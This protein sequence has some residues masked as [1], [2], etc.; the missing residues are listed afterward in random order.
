MKLRVQDVS[1]SYPSVPALRRVSLEVGRSEIISI[2]GPNGS[3]KSTMIKCID[4]ILK[5]HRGHITLDEQDMF[6]MTRKEI[7]QRIAYVPQSSLQTFPMTVFDVVLMGRHPHYKWGSSR[8]AD[9]H[10]AQ[11]VLELLEIEELALRNFNALSGGQQQTV[12]LARAL[13]QEAE[14]LLLDEPTSNLD[15][16]HQLEFVETLAAMVKA[17]KLSVI[18]SMHDLNLAARYSDRVILLNSGRI[19]GVGTPSEVVTSQN[20][21]KIYSVDAA[22]EMIDGWPYVVPLRRSPRTRQFWKKMQNHETSLKKDLTKLK[23]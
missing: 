4:R 20:I 18:M 10:K 21:L 6:R 1:F 16:Y 8:K 11:H 5:P 2:I 9:L 12:L 7:A 15:I 3:G 22:V 23:K 14:I 19:E 13:A 17:K